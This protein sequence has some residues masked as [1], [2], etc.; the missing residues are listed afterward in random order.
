MFIYSVIP[1][2]LTL[3]FSPFYRRFA[4]RYKILDIPNQRKIH[5]EP[6]P[7]S[8]GLAIFTSTIITFLIFFTKLKNFLLLIV[9][10][11]F[12]VIIG[13][14]NDRKNLS[15]SFRLVV[16]IFCALLFIFFAER[17]SFLP[18]SFL[19]DTLEIIISLIWIIGITNAYNYLDGLDGL[20]AGSAVINFFYFSIIL[21]MNNQPALAF[22][23]LIMLFSCL[24]FLPYN[25]S[26]T[27][28]VFL[29]DAGSTFLGFVLACIGIL[30]NWAEDNFVK[31]AIPILIL[32]VPIFDMTFTTIMRFKE[33]KIRTIIEW[34]EYAGKDHFHHYLLELG[35][36]PNAAAFLI[37]LFTV[38]LGM[39]A[40]MVSNDKAPEA[41]LTLTQAIVLFIIIGMLI[42]MGKYNKDRVS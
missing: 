2:F 27:K 30:G 31:V 41:F 21:F 42:V 28:K 12:I 20:A 40:I 14:I 33:K 36:L 5:K 16:Q 17:I 4:I 23:C 19:G 6:V 10:S 11:F 34:L 1:F 18:K 25:F 22:F 38:S 39:S 9:L 32:G 35:F 3:L 24:G 26:K 15:A 7:L 13:V 8:G 29:G 37:F